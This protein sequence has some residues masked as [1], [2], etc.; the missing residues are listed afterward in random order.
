MFWV[1]LCLV[2]AS[3]SYSD[4]LRSNA[5][6]SFLMFF[7]G[8]F[9]NHI[10]VCVLGIFV[11]WLNW[12]WPDT[13]AT[14]SRIALGYMLV[15]LIFFPLELMFL[16]A[17]LLVI[18]QGWPTLAQVW[19]G[20]LEM[21]RFGWFT[22]LAWSSGTYIGVVALC[23]WRRQR[24]RERDIL[25]LRLQIL[26][27]QL[28]PHFM[29]NALNA[30]SALV[31]ADDRALALTGIR[32]LSDLLRYARTVS[33]REWVTVADELDFIRDY[34][35]LQQLRYGDRLRVRIDGDDKQVLNADCPPLLLQPLVENAL[36]HGLDR[37]GGEGEVWIG[38]ATDAQMLSVRI[39]NQVPDA[40]HS[41]GVG[42][43]LQN[44]RMRLQTA[45]G[46]AASLWTTEQDGSF[47]AELRMPKWAPQ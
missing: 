3:G 1:V 27:G 21:R 23:L 13:F 18:K 24:L 47:T 15:L 40:P 32:R 11:H 7:Q 5:D 30:I 25:S 4:A 46:P 38:F 45:Y 17:R 29:F 42:T 16:E 26:R 8:W 44:V 33:E 19:Q 39:L 37:D 28:E 20:V 14:A 34:L 12:R 22:E 6:A 35:A 41:P 9:W 36:R 10:P 43:G 31:R 2:G